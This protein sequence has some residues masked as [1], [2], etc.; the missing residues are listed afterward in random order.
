MGDYPSNGR[1]SS[2]PKLNKSRRNCKEYISNLLQ[3]FTLL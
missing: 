2:I 3:T 1:P